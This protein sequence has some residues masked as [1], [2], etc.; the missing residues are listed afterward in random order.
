MCLRVVDAEFPQN[1]RR[2]ASQARVMAWRV[3]TNLDLRVRP[4]QEFGESRRAVCPLPF[5]LVPSF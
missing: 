4:F 2:L 5:R 1:P 3:L